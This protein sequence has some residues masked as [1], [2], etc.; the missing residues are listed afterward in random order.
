MLKVLMVTSEAAPFAKTGGLADMVSALSSSLKGFD[1]DVRIIMPRYYRINKDKLEKLPPSLHV[2]MPY[3]DEWAAVFQGE[4]PGSKVPVYFL[5]HEELYGRSGIYGDTP[6]EGFHDNARRYSFLCRAVFQICRMI[7]WIPN[8]IHCHDWASALVPY[9]LR[10]EEYSKEFSGTFSM[11]TIHNLG[12]QGIFPLSDTSLVKRNLLGWD[13]PDLEF[14]KALNFLKTGINFSDIIT[15]VSPTYANEIQTPQYGERLEYLLRYRKDDLFGILNGADYTDWNPETDT[16]ISPNNFSAS[17]IANKNKVK[18]NLQKEFGLP[19]DV[20][21]PVFG[22]VTRLVSQKGLIEL[23]YPSTG[24]LYNI[25]KDFKLQFVILGSGNKWCEDELKRL[26]ARLP[27]LKIWIGYNER[28]SHIIEAGSDF[29]LMP[30]KYEPCGLNQI[31]SMRYGTIPI[32]RNT[33]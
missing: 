33:G 29:F 21:I 26:A 12:Y 20:N 23:C 28:I 15:T 6:D 24:S 16:F 5:E 25:C 2:P 10:K 3:G 22:M 13:I 7:N 31:Y 11:L 4:L 8:I 9:I 30:S 18:K 27:N 32:V 19:V 14:D 1:I 17:K